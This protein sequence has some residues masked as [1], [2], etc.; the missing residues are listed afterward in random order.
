MRKLKLQVQLS[1][2]GYVGAPN[3]DLDWS[4]KLDEACW[5]VINDL[6]DT[7]DTLLL[8]RKMALDFVSHFESFA[9]ENNRY[10]FAQKMVN[11]PKVIFTKTLDHPFGR[12]TSL[13]KGNLGD[14]ISRLKNQ[15]GKDILVYGG[16]G[17]VSSLVAGGHIDEFYFFV[18]PVMI[19]KGLRIFDL[20]ST[21]QKLSLVSATPYECGVTVLCYT[22][23]NK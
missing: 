20:L 1:V 14:E 10:T 5:K 4:T 2:D 12:N 3:G 7:S 15:E 22:L 6:A 18:N 19:S 11:I 21:R 13:A 8:G 17:F 9:T 16:A 23:N